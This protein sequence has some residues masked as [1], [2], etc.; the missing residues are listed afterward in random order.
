MADDALRPDGSRKGSGFL[1]TLKRPDG[2][3]MSE[4]SVG[5]PVNGQETDIP[6]IVPGL[7]KAELDAIL[8]WQEGQELPNSVYDK[9]LAFAKQRAAQGRP[10]F[11]QPGEQDF[12]AYPDIPREDS[13]HDVPLAS[14]RKSV[15]PDVLGRLALRAALKGR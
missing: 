13:V 15:D 7:T 14:S 3:V 8:K 10:F 1:G 2:G 4:L 12:D 11:A 9:A 6:S 5:L